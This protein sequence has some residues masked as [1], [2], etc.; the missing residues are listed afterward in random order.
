MVFDGRDAGHIYLPA[1]AADP[2]ATALLLRPRFDRDL[3]PSALQDIFRRVAP[4]PQVFEAIPL[5]EMR[6]AQ[7]YP[8]RAAAW[9]GSMLGGIAL[10]L[11]V[12]G[13]YGV[14]SY[15]LTQRTREIGIRMALGA[16]AAAVVR[17]LMG[18]SARLAGI[19]AA[20]GLVCAFSVLKVL[21]SPFTFRRFR[22]WTAWHS[23]V[24][25][26]SSRRRRPSP[27]ITRPAARPA[28]IRP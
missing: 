19:G 14:L 9:I 21:S 26:P 16:T 3:G 28:W 7:M 22:C 12:S 25:S 8:I 2:H 5:G 17:L 1:H 10:V 13:L 23:P 11:S 24:A 4:D 18:Q 20:I 15:T 6:S 27:R